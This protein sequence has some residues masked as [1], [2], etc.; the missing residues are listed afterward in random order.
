[1]KKNSK[2][3]KFKVLL[4]EIIFE[5]KMKFSEIEKLFKNNMPFFA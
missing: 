2:K 4:N 5:S 1:M 3:S